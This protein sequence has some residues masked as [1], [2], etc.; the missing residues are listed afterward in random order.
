[1]LGDVHLGENSLI[2]VKRECGEGDLDTRFFLH[3][4]PVDA[5]DL[6]DHRK[7]HGFDNLD[8]SLDTHGTACF[9]EVPLPEYA[10]AAVSTGQF[11]R[12]DNGG[13][14]TIWEGEISLDE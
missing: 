5:D 1:M 6:P 11:V 4:H 7:Q 14:R 13:F 3:V 10:I 12:T 2:Y 9:A 8:F